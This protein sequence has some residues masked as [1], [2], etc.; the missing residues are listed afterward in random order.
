[1]NRRSI[2]KALAGVAAAAGLVACGRREVEEELAIMPEPNIID[3]E[4]RLAEAY[5]TTLIQIREAD[6]SVR[7]LPPVIF[8]S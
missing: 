1:M 6:G 4:K 8:S 2:F 5:K 7:P 3:Y